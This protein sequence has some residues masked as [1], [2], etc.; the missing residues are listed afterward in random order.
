VSLLLTILLAIGL[1]LVA[2][3]QTYV[4]GAPPGEGAAASS[5]VHVDSLCALY[6]IPPESCPQEWRCPILVAGDL[7]IDRYDHP[8]S[9]DCPSCR[10]FKCSEADLDSDG[11]VGISDTAICSTLQ[12]ADAESTRLAQAA[13]SAIVQVYYGRTCP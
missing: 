2:L 4:T 3:G 13:C 6:G 9:Q 12:G 1:P 5:G 11:V 7:V 10:H 8:R